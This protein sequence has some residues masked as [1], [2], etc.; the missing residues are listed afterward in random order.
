MLRE[1]ASLEDYNRYI[2][3]YAIGREKMNTDF[4]AKCGSFM[5]MMGS[6]IP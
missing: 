3:V 4:I 6:L 1:C 5:D 2:P